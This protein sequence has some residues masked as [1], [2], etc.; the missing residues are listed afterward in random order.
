MFADDIIWDIDL[1]EGETYESARAELELPK[2]VELPKWL[3]PEDDVE[4]MLNDPEVFA[5][6]CVTADI[7]DWLSDEYGYC[8]KSFAL[9]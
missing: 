1:E 3:W 9:C 4:E 8:V 6:C 2:C 5:P 7:E